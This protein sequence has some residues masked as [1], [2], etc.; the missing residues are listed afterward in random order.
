MSQPI[1]LITVTRATAKY[2]QGCS[3]A[4]VRKLARNNEFGDC[5]RTNGGWLIPVPGILAWQK[6]HLIG[7]DRSGRIPDPL[8]T[9]EKL[10]NFR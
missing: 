5:I 8:L 10:E 9:E 1:E 7:P 2:F 4:Y 3:T 6:R